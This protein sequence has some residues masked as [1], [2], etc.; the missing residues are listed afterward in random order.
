MKHLLTITEI[1]HIK[2]GKVIWEAFNIPNTLHLE[3]EEFVLSTVFRSASGIAIPSFYYL[4]MDNRD[5]VS[6]TDNM[7]SLTTEPSGNGYSRQAVSSATGFTIEQFTIEGDSSGIQHWRAKSQIVAFT[8]SGS[9]WG[10]VSNVFLTDRI[11]DT[12][13][14]ISTAALGVTR[15][16]GPGETLT[17]RFTLNVVDSSIS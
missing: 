5:V 2:D 3:G 7:Q 13:Y 16:V 4:G 11:D 9:S 17:F 14:L 1:K 8:A 10:P 12:G 15:L 6:V